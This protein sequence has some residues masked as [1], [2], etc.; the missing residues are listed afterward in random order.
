M[1]KY[2]ISERAMLLQLIIYD[3]FEV[4]NWH[5]SPIVYAIHTELAMK[6]SIVCFLLL[7]IL[8]RIILQYIN[9]PHQ[10][11]SFVLIY[12][13]YLQLLT[14]QMISLT[15]NARNRLKIHVAKSLIWMIH[16]QRSRQPL[17]HESNISLIHQVTN[18]CLSTWKFKLKVYDFSPKATA[19]QTITSN[20]LNYT[21]L[22]HKK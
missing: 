21:S 7:E 14:A 15:T 6:V 19:H 16:M 17:M 5:F 2:R 10:L 4:Q 3:L 1:G 12:A 11:N 18:F 22:T 13:V 9:L 8:R 20:Q